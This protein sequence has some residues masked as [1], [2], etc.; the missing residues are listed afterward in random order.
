MALEE[1][2]TGDLVVVDPGA[3]GDGQGAVRRIAYSPGNGT[4]VARV[5]AADLR[6]ARS[7]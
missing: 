4:P 3:F 1:A 5:Q 6:S 7:R 2:P